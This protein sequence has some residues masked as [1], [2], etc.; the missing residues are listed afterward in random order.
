M[1]VLSS[2]SRAICKQKQGFPDLLRDP[3]CY[4]SLSQET[5]EFEL[6]LNLMRLQGE[7][8][9]GKDSNKHD[10]LLMFDYYR[11]VRN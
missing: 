4:A 7:F 8:Q 3:P 2:S 9:Q 5:L 1:Q 11:H 10:F 6:T